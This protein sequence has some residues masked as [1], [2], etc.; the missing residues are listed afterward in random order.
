MITLSK[1]RRKPRH[2]RA[3]TGLT[4]FEF[5]ALLVELTPVYE[6]A[7]TQRSRTPD[8]LRDAGADTAYPEVA[9]QQPIKKQR[10]REVTVLERA[11]NHSLSV[12]R[13][14]VEHHFARLKKWGCMAGVWRGKFAD[15]EGVFC[16]IAGLLN[17]RH[18]GKFELIG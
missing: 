10:N 2:F 7:L 12:K 1:L 11:Y 15:H 4:P 14:A 3:F 5:D 9:V 17:F 6:A 16:V 13:I 18:T 8:R